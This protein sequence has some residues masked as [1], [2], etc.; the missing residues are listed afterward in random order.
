MHIT[1]SLMMLMHQVEQMT[2]GDMKHSFAAWRFWQKAR[3]LVRT[4]TASTD[5]NAKACTAQHAQHTSQH[6]THSTHYLAAQTE[7]PGPPHA[8]TWTN[9]WTTAGVKQ[10]FMKTHLLT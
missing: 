10:K 4:N 5:Q 3:R 7:K 6:S 8:C 1:A 2:F 9:T